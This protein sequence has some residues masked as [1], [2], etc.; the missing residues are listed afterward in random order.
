MSRGIYV[1]LSGAVAQQTALDNTAQNLANSQSPGYSRTRVV[2]RE[3]LAA[4]RGETRFGTASETVLDRSQ[5]ALRTT[6]RQLDVALPE[7]TFLAVNTSRGERY[8]RAGGL[9]MQ[10]D[11]ALRTQSGQAV[12]DEQK[13]PITLDPLAGE[14][15]ITPAGD[16]MQRGIAVAQLRTVT[17]NDPSRL[18]HEEA[19]VVAATPASGDA[20]PVA[21]ELQ[22]GML[23]DSNGNVTNAMN[24]IVTASRTFEAFQT[25][26]QTFGEIDRKLVNTVPNGGSGG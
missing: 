16:V 5:G 19:S 14:P 25:A 23:E 18:A 1:A 6:G 26:I 2:F 24:E 4:A 9:S 13:K 7:G 10:P 21:A 15:S 8:T 11:G 17:F 20:K 22:V 12:L 3:V